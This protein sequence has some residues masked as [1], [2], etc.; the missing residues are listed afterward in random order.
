ML[1]IKKSLSL[2][3]GLF[4]LEQTRTNDQAVFSSGVVS[5]AF[6]ASANT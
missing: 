4:C 3:E 1:V 2:A 6:G 5:S